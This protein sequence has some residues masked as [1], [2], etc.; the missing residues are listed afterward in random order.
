MATTSQPARDG[1]VSVIGW[2]L[3]GIVAW[4]ACLD[5]PSRRAENVGV[6]ASH[7]GIGHHPA[8]LWVVADR[9]SQAPGKWAPFRPRP[10]GVARTPPRIPPTC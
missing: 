7:F 9:L 3:G 8:A 5:Q 4:R 1:P 2:S 6:Y 10:G